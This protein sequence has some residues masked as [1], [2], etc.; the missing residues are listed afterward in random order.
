MKGKKI[1]VVDDDKDTVEMI[2]KMLTAEDYTVLTAENGARAVEKTNQHHIDLILL[3]NRMP[4]F[5]GVWYCNAL[6]HKP[7]TKNIPIVL[8]SGSLDD[9]TLSR[10]KDAGASDFL[11]KPFLADDLL[12]VVAK[13]ILR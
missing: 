11:K 9:E 6:R 2:E 8:V 7:N 4:L 13:N 3:D 5:S 10:A 1:L 12:K